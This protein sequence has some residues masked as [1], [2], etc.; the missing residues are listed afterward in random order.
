M[1]R[2]EIPPPSR[3]A[4]RPLHALA[5]VAIIAAVLA[6][7]GR[8]WALPEFPG[9]VQETLGL[10]CVPPCTICHL[11]PTPQLGDSAD[12]RF[13]ANVRAMAGNEGPNEQNL[14]SILTRLETLPCPNMA[15]PS[16]S[17]GTCTQCNAD[18]VGEPDIAELKANE[19]PNN[20]S[21][22]PCV[23]YGCFARVAPA[24]PKRSLDGTAVLAALG[25]ALVLVGRWRRRSSR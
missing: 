25:T 21:T 23:E 9:I 3:R 5:L 22:L 1:T 15:D 11:M 16:C 18:G 7:S 17:S 20:S 2:R 4:A 12:Q 14:A 6:T 10:T 8:A 19:N 24:P 13:A